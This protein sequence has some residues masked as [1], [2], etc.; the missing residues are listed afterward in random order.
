MRYLF[1]LHWCSGAEDFHETPGPVAALDV[2][3]TPRKNVVLE[4]QK[5]RLR[6]Q[7]QDEMI[8]TF[9]NALRELAKSCEFG[10]LER[11]MI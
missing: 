8:D 1:A 3:F 10:A 11:D 5:F 2:Y 4:R 9:V 7:L 6:T